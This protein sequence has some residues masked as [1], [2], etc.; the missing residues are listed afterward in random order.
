VAKEKRI[1]RYLITQRVKPFGIWPDGL[2]TQS[3]AVKIHPTIEGREYTVY[4][5]LGVLRGAPQSF[6]P[7]RSVG[8]WLGGAVLHSVDETT[9]IQSR[10]YDAAPDELAF[11]LGVSAAEPLPEAGLLKEFKP[12]L[13]SLVSFCGLVL[14]DFFAPTLSME[15]RQLNDD[16]S[17]KRPATFSV[18]ARRRARVTGDQV[19]DLV[20]KFL[21][22][23]QTLSPEES[24]RLDVALR[25]Y[26]TSLTE[27][28][29]VDRVSD[30]WEAC[31]VLTKDLTYRSR[32]IKGD[33]ASRI[34]FA[35]AQHTGKL[36]ATIENRL[37]R[38]MYILRSDLVHNAIETADHLERITGIFEHATKELL[39]FRMDLPYA[40]DAVLDGFIDGD[41]STGA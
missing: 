26:Q 19:N 29:I 10:L 37:V 18:L 21:V 38:P 35:L 41:Q 16:D 6:A 17:S 23:R 11:F 39:R 2:S 34:A 9:S 25:R 5:A 1:Y 15:I 4:V 20:G 36:K 33:I 7:D 40:G 13:L 3:D 14:G 28:D 31:E 8:F 30:L 22:V 27:E 24:R 32:K 12:V